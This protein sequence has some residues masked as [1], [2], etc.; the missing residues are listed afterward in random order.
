[1]G[2]KTV[3][4]NNLKSEKQDNSLGIGE[5]KK[6]LTIDVPVSLHTQLKIASAKRGET[7]AEIVL[8]MLKKELKE[9]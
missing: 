1:M 3:I 5:K 9:T 4:K 7:M 2:K 8:N 6:R